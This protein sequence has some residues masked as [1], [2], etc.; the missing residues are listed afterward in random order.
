M[1][2]ARFWSAVAI[3]VALLVALLPL[4]SGQRPKNPP[5]AQPAAKASASDFWFAATSDERWFCGPGKWDTSQYFRGVCEAL[6]AVGKGEFLVG[7]GDIDPVGDNYWT[8]EKYL[9]PN[10]TWYPVVGNHDCVD[11]GAGPDMPWTRSF[12]AG[13]KRLPHIVN[14]GPENGVETNYSFDYG[15]AHFIALN[16]YYD[17]QSDHILIRDEGRPAGHICDVLYKWL[18]ADLA[19]TTKK[20]I[21][22]LGH[23]PAYV[24]PDLDYGTMD[25]F[26]ASLNVHSKARDRFWKL[27][28]SKHVAAYLCGHTHS[29]SCVKVDGIWQ[30]DA[31]QARGGG[32][33]STFVRIHVMDS[34]IT[35]ESYR[36]NPVG[37]KYILKHTWRLLPAP[38]NQPP[39]E[40]VSPR[41]PH[42]VSTATNTTI[43][44]RVMAFDPDGDCRSL[45][46]RVV[47]LPAHGKLAEVNPPR[48]PW[49]FGADYDYTPEKGFNGKDTFA[50]KA[51]DGQADS[52]PI[53]V[54]INV[55][56]RITV[57]TFSLDPAEQVAEV[58]S[59][60]EINIRATDQF[61]AWTT[62]DVAWS[63]SA[64]TIA[65]MSKTRGLLKPPAGAGGPYTVTAKA[66]G[67][68]A[69]AAVTVV[70]V[71]KVA[72][73]PTAKVSG[74][75]VEL[76]ALGTYEGGE[77][78]LTYSWHVGAPSDWP[79]TFSDNHTNSAKKTTATFA[80]AGAYAIELIIRDKE[81][82]IAKAS[83]DVK[84]N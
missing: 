78:N 2:K 24:Q 29:N 9:G 59:E 19:A 54:T 30:I 32:E 56:P 16:E 74:K 49:S 38:P 70:N 81:G 58:G 63:A 6:A 61:G 51:N 55:A 41:N 57:A 48:E 68:T 23:E 21:V 60:F 17:G 8:V 73:A 33:G 3:T 52:K 37:P 39:A 69:T 26:Y 12:N 42:L 4:L 1:R 43:P 84:V 64:G 83:V 18:E 50:V 77:P 65:P 66:G 14:S 34:G 13:G 35:A 76:S 25:N 31:G 5:A 7:L 27:L 45:K 72:T 10:Y 75:T 11:K 44:V 36:M 22:V 80:R 82:G 28:Q 53:T 40:F 15:N 62:P 67:K 46:Y 71:P 79:V 47:T 20:Y